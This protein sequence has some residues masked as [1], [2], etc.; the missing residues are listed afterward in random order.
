MALGAQHM[1]N[2]VVAGVLVDALAAV[3]RR[4]GTAVSALPDRRYADD[5]AIARWFDTYR[6]TE[7]VP[8]L[9]GL[10]AEAAARLA[11]VLSKDEVQAVLHELLAAR[12]TAQP[13]EENAQHKSES[14][15]DYPLPADVGR[16]APS[17]QRASKDH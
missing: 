4:L 3:G 9:P 2:E 17:S 13:N 1:L 10:S 16:A 12:L 11:D 14:S 15:S 5:V 8:S 7:R 6:L